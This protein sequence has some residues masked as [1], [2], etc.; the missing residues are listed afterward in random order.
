M[1][2]LVFRLAAAADVEDAY[3]WYEE[4][5]AGLGEELLSALTAALALVADLP[6][7]FPI[8]HRDTRRALL[9]RFPYALYY[10]I[11]D[12]CIVVVGCLHARREPRIWQSRR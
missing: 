12:D 11:L 4:Q 2:P 1:K 6:L 10:R 5:R 7:A 8:V 3:R 9:K